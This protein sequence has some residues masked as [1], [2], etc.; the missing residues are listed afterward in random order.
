VIG[1]TLTV[2]PTAAAV[3]A[4]VATAAALVA[5][6]VWL[7]EPRAT[8]TGSWLWFG[9][10]SVLVVAT[11]TSVFAVP[12]GGGGTGLGGWTEAIGRD[13]GTWALWFGGL[14]ASVAVTLFL[15]VL[16]RGRERIRWIVLVG[17]GVAVTAAAGTIAGVL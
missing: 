3:S 7:T 14:V 2:G 13:P 1:P 4:I 6:G 5:T 15:S 11:L 8:S 16:F 12:S 10:E 9:V 17:C